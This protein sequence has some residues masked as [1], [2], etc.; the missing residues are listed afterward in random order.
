MTAFGSN[1]V[2]R[3]ATDRELQ[4]ALVS[5]A[6]RAPSVHNVQPA[7][8]RFEPNGGVRLFRA[9]RRVLPTADPSGHDVRLSLGAAWE[10]L[11]IALSRCGLA[12]TEPEPLSANAGP[13]LAPIVHARLVASHNG[14][15]R[16]ATWVEKRRSYRG[17]FQRT[18]PEVLERLEAFRADD[19]S[20][21]DPSASL[22]PF[23]A[24]YDHANYAFL[25]N[26]AYQDEL[27]QWLRLERSH[28]DWGRDGINADCLA[29]S[30][31]ERWVASVAFRPRVFRRLVHVG[32]GR[33]LVSEAAQIRSAAALLLF[34]PER[35]LSEFAVG[36]R[37]YRLWLELTAL[38]LS[39]APMSALADSPESAA[40][41]SEMHGIPASRR[42]A[43]V[44]RVGTP[45]PRGVARSPRLPVG[46]LLV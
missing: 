8:W 32:I 26:P 45:P 10:G 27:Y 3:V 41:L 34:V 25:T 31:S 44:F 17:T 29:L 28:R 39:L 19:V 6:A 1:A 43:N 21:T 16:L 33:M 13:D 4:H 20:F 15:D 23:A 22:A 38:G 24:M 5:E 7:R 36:R 14:E 42:L 18:S 11:S 12:L 46:E 2:N 37:F 9:T 30:A 40:A 35:S